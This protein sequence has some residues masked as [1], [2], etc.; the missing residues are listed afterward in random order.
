ML[1]LFLTPE[2]RPAIQ[3]NIPAA[4]LDAPQAGNGKSLLAEVVALK[5]TGTSRLM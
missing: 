5:S 1:A 3:G 4:L 2:I